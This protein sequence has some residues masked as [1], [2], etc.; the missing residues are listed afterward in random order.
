MKNN[1]CF[2]MVVKVIMI[3]QHHFWNDIDGW[4]FFFFFNMNGFTMNF[5]WKIDGWVEFF[6]YEHLYTE[7][8]VGDW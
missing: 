6:K 2:N 5:K 7:L 4:V 1:I 8:C 3:V